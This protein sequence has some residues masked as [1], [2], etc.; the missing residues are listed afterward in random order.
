MQPF[1]HEIN[2]CPCSHHTTFHLHKQLDFTRIRKEAHLMLD[3]GEEEV[4]VEA[5]GNPKSIE[6]KSP[7]FI[8]GLSSEAMRGVVW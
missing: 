4:V 2:T 3:R 6:V 8:G 1:S 5:P 7:H